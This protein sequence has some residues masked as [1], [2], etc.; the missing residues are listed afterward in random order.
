V[1]VDSRGDI[2]RVGPAPYLSDDRLAE[3]IDALAAALAAVAG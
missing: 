3:G 1:L 2:L